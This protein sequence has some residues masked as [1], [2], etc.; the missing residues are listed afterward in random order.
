MFQD[1][2]TIWLRELKLFF[3]KKSRVLSSLLFPFFWLFIFGASFGS[4][5][6]TQFEGV[7][8]M[9]FMLP[10]V[11]GLVILFQSMFFGVSIIWDR[12]FGFLKEM[13]VAPITRN[14]I[15]MGKTLGGVTTVFFQVIIVW[16]LALIYGVPMNLGFFSVLLAILVIFVTSSTFVLIGIAIASRLS[17]PQGFQFIMNLFIA[18]LFFLS[19]VFFPITQLPSWISWASYISPLTYGIDALREL[20]TGASVFLLW[21]NLAVVAGVFIA[22][23]VLTDQLFKHSPI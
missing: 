5:V 18:P 4:V 20:M 17:D 2:Y 22:I 1:I 8:Y 15:V 19:G 12:R 14:S 21:Q 23:L 3:R 9:T 11:I 13:L 10:G 6:N 7:D 16:I